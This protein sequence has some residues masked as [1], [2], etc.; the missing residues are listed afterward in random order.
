[1]EDKKL[2]QATYYF[3]I[4]TVRISGPIDVVDETGEYYVTNTVWVLKSDINKVKYTGFADPSL[5]VTMVNATEEQLRDALSKWF[6]D[7]SYK[8]WKM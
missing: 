1:M 2:I 6:S 5:E 4:D 7:K 8:V 3:D